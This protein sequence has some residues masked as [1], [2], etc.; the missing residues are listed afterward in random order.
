[1]V[2][3]WSPHPD[4]AQR[5][6]I[7]DAM[8]A[9]QAEDAKLPVL[10]PHMYKLPAVLSISGSSF[11]SGVRSSATTGTTHTSDSFFPN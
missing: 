2:V 4:P 8:H 7:V 9:L 5:P 1:V 3:L 11:S 10:P 6:S